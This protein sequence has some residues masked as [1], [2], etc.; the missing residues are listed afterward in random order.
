MGFAH[1]MKISL[2][3][4]KK[5]MGC[6]CVR[7]RVFLSPLITPFYV[8]NP[9]IIKQFVFFVFFFSYIDCWWIRFEF[10]IWVFIV[11]DAQ[12]GPKVTPLDPSTVASEVWYGEESGKYPF[13]QRGTSTIY[14]QFYPFTGL[15]NYTS[16]IIH[17]VRI[18]GEKTHLQWFCDA[19]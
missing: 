19:N 13:D 12:I 11:G 7:A 2:I 8:V 16:G 6:V 9:Q 14:N 5:D 17:H 4:L 1:S 10:Q 18:Q 15:W 3:T